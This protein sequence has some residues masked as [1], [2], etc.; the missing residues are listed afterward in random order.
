MGGVVYPCGSRIHLVKYTKILRDSNTITVARR[1]SMA[2]IEN[3]KKEAAQKRKRVKMFRDSKKEGKRMGLDLARAAEL[4]DT[5]FFC[6]S[7]H[8]ADGNMDALMAC[9]EALLGEC[10]TV[11]VL[12]MSAGQDLV[13]CCVVPEEKV[14]IIAADQWLCAALKP[15]GGS[16]E[17]GSTKTFARAHVIPTENQ[18]AIK[19]KDQMLA[20]A[21]QALREKA[22]IIDDS[23]DGLCL[24]D[25]DLGNF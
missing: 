11:G 16:V 17:E 24:G 14:D 18:F 2:D 4:C 3:F 13:A 8:G 20:A 25:E 12:F 19:L 15:V 21:V 22:K 23:D 9:K 5:E 7:C 6:T 1:L 10:T